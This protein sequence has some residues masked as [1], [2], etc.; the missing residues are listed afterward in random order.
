MVTG[1]AV[2]DK[3]FQGGIFVGCINFDDIGVS[4]RPYHRN[5]NCPLHKMHEN[6]SRSHETRIMGVSYPVKRVWSEGSLAK[7]ASRNDSSPCHY[8]E[9]GPTMKVASYKRSHF[10]FK[11]GENLEL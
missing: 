2:G 7:M 4:R 8:M 5:C 6:H 9:T 3:F 1:F 10:D 11:S